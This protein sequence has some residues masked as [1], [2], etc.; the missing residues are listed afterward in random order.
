MTLLFNKI[1]KQS[2]S[3][4]IILSYHFPPIFENEYKFHNIKIK[5][6]KRLRDILV[7]E[8]LEEFIQ[9]IKKVYEKIDK[10]KGNVLVVAH[11]SSCLTIIAITTGNRKEGGKIVREHSKKHGNTCVSILEKERDKY[12]I[13]LI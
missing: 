11:G 10:E 12:Q 3:I 9:K 6:D 13:R 1:R 4:P 8:N 5:L 2:N 7:E